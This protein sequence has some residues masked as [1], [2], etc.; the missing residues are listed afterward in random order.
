MPE[1]AGKWAGQMNSICGKVDWNLVVKNGEV[2]G[3]AVT[4]KREVFSVSGTVEDNGEIS[5]G[6]IEGP[7]SGSTGSQR[8]KFYW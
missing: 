4:E 6:L 8:Y 5:S 2:S 7:I 1:V 3:E